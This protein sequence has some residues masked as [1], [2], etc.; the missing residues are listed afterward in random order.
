MKYYEC[1]DIVLRDAARK[2]PVC[3]Q[4]SRA[5]PVLAVFRITQARDL[6]GQNKKA[7]NL[8]NGRGLA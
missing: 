7:L 2:P 1:S 4:L 3:V 5:H 6:L 8:T